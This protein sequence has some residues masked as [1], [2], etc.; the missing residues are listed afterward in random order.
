MSGPNTRM[1]SCRT[2][3]SGKI[4]ARLDRILH[5]GGDT[6]QA[7][8]RHYGA[9]GIGPDSTVPPLPLVIASSPSP[10]NPGPAG[11]RAAGP[12]AAPLC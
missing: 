2:P 8:G 1:A 11:S 5:A 7:Y 12:F 9:Q 10:A 3:W 6:V 4:L